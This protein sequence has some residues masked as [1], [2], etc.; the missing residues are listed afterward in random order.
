[1]KT[2]GTTD[3][4]DPR[5]TEMDPVQK[6]WMMN[7]FIEDTNDNVELLKQLGY[8]IGS[9]TNP[10]AVKQIIGTEGKHAS[11]DEEFDESVEMV[12]RANEKI[13]NKKINNKQENGER[14]RRR[15]IK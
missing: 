13:N 1:M 5:I 9:F 14:R 12:R 7:N 3:M 8:L 2:L 11:T 15:V 4:N 6:A 10:E